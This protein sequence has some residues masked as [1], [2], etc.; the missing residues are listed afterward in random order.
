MS[1][2]VDASSSMEACSLLMPTSRRDAPYDSGIFIVEII[3]SE[4][5]AV[6]RYRHTA[7]RVREWMRQRGMR[8]LER[9]DPR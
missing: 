8:P 4:Y 7:R 3:D 1:M 6:A 2:V 5:R 9:M